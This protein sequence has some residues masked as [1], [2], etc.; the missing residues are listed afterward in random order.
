M[1]K[2]LKSR[3]FTFS[4]P[5]RYREGVKSSGSDAICVSVA[6][7]AT[8]VEKTGLDSFSAW[9]DWSPWW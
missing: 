5:K 7:K 1:A 9:I 2:I 4:L 8:E 3:P 6:V